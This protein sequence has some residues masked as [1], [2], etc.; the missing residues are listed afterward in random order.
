MA[1]APEGAAAVLI[2]LSFIPKLRLYGELHPIS[3][4][5]HGDGEVVQH[6]D[7]LRN[8]QAHAAA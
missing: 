5:F 3:C 4:V 2:S 8:G 6:E 7:L 1:A